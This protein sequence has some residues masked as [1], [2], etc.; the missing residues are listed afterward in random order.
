MADNSE[1][2]RSEAAMLCGSLLF[3]DV[4]RAEFNA[5]MTNYKILQAIILTNS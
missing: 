2:V 4:G 3:L 1:E 5:K